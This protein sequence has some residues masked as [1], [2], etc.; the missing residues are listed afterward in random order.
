M[1]ILDDFHNFVDE[2]AVSGKTLSQ[3]VTPQSVQNLQIE[4]DMIEKELNAF[5]TEYAA[6]QNDF[7]KNN[8]LNRLSHIRILT[9]GLY[10]HLRDG[11]TPEPNPAYKIHP[12]YKKVAERFATVNQTLVD[13]EKTALNCVFGYKQA[14][15]S[16]V[17]PEL[18]ASDQEIAAI[19]NQSADQTAHCWRLDD[20]TQ[21]L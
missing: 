12:L 5:Q 21:H 1:S 18:K 7:Q 16:V 15:N 10:C 6:A 17:N 11:G 8:A 14:D 20:P 13:L 3:K 9:Q 19:Q 4:L 2:F